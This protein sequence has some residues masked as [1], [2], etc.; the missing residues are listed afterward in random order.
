MNNLKQQEKLFDEMFEF[1]TGYTTATEVMMIEREKVK[2]EK[3]KQFWSDYVKDTLNG[4][5][6]EIEKADRQEVDWE[7]MYEGLKDVIKDI[8]K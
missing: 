2:V 5:L 8:L 4:L 7:D 6:K 3:V 1:P